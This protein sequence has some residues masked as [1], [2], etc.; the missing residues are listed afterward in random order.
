MLRGN[1]RKTCP[2]VALKDKDLPDEKIRMNKCIRKNLRVNLGDLVCVK[3]K[4][5]IPNLTKIHVLPFK[6]S[7]E[8]LEGDLAQTYLV[9]Y[10]NNAYRPV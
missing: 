6:D 5:N 7:I 10:F 9:P 2:A 8:G 1:K 4:E 3:A